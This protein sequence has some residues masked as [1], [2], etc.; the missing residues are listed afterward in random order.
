MQPDTSNPSAPDPPADLIFMMGKF[1]ARV[2]QDRLYAKNHMWCQSDGARHRF[3]FTS[4]AVRLLQD[5]YFL[6]W[7]VDA[8]TSVALRQE[9]GSIESSKAESALYAPMTGQIVEFNQALLA[10]PAAINL[11]NFGAG[12]L[13]EMTGDASSMLGPADYLDHLTGV[14]EVTQRTI[15]GQLG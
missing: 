10:D 12:W 4:Y 2:P 7:S 13:F 8:G 15:K 9:I 14:W 5:V 11:D 3:G 6:E 1:E